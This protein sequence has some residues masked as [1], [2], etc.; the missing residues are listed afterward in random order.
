M[1]VCY[2]DYVDDVALLAITPPQAEILLHSLKQTAGGNDVHVNANK[3]DNMFTEEFD[4]VL[5]IK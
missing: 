4:A 3:T 5:K 2:A 1:C